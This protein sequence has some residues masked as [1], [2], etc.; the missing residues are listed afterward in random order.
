MYLY[1]YKKVIDIYQ[2][3][4]KMGSQLPVAYGCI[5]TIVQQKM[6]EGYLIN[7]TQ[8]VFT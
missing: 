5:N 1:R 6:R 4:K 2:P 3:D 7:F 8:T